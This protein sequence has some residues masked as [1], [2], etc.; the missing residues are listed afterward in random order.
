MGAR[1]GAAY[2]VRVGILLELAGVAGIGTVVRPDASWWLTL[3]FLFVYG[4]GVGLATAQLTGVVLVDVPLAQSGQ[5][6]GTQSTSRQ[7]GSAL[8]IAIL[9]TVL[10]TS[11][12]SALTSRVSQLPGIPAAQREQLV[13]AVVDSAGAA[14]SGLAANPATAAVADAAR[15]AFTD[16]TRYAAFSAAGFLV[17]GFL[18][19]LSLGRSNDVV[20]AGLEDSGVV[21]AS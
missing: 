6:S 4:M 18:A 3:P 21:G 13:S 15:V 20:G 12:G 1:R 19:S 5:G 14:I 11:L 7:I 9:G 16:A 10:F 2:V 17:L 8:G